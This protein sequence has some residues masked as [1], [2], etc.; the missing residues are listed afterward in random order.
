MNNLRLIPNTHR[1]QE[2]VKAY[3]KRCLYPHIMGH[4]FATHLLETGTDIRSIQKL[5]EHGSRKQQ[6]YTHRYLRKKLGK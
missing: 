6:R 5:L 4:L 2:I 3:I 1:Q